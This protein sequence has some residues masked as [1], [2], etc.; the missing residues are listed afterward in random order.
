[1]LASRRHTRLMKC[2]DSM[3]ALITATRNSIRTVESALK[4]ASTF[5]NQ[6]KHYLIDGAST[7]G[8]REF[9]DSF[10]AANHNSVLLTQTG[11]GLYAALNEAIDAAVADPAITQIGF[12]H[13]DDRL[14]PDC[15]GEYLAHINASQCEFFYSDIAYHDSTDRCVRVWSAGCFSRFKLRTGWM[16]P[17]TSVIVATQIYR[18]YGNYNPAFG[19]AADYEW[20]VRVMSTSTLPV[21]YFPKRTLTMLVGGASGATLASRLKA[22]AMDGKVWADRSRVQSWLIRLLKP[23]RKL[24]QFSA[25]IRSG[26]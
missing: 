4:S 5:R 20:I 13:S 23:M 26:N 21:S 25:L 24:L 14:I 16:P 19:T 15:F 10:V 22:N 12:L 17:H 9:L 6:V 8:T 3:L 18:H 1:M 7:D 2:D 11:T